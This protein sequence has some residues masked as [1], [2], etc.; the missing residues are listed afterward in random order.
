MNLI[1]DPVNVAC[2]RA[3]AKT[4][5]ALQSPEPGRAVS[6]ALEPGR[7][8]FCHGASI[9]GHDGKRREWERRTKRAR[10]AE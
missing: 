10:N 6:V 7:D 5:S 4:W 2:S 3:A 9:A 8:S 1:S